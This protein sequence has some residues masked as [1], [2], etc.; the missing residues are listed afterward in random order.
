MKCRNKHIIDQ[1]FQSDEKII[2][3]SNHI[4]LLDPFILSAVTNGKI[5]YVF[6]KRLVE[7]IPGF[8]Y[9]MEH[10]VKSLVKQPKDTT[11]QIKS[12]VFSR[13]K[14][15]PILCLFADAMNQVPIDKNIAP[16]KTG[17]FV[18]KIPI[19]PII[20]KYKNYKIDPTYRWY[21]NE[22]FLWGFSKVLFDNNIDIVVDIGEPITPKDNWSIEDFR[23]NVYEMMNRKYELI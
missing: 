9:I 1:S 14:N 15:E 17:A 2:I 3:V 18:H 20:I 4:S 6:E 22:H 13:Q 23:D 8:K 10:Y 21:N 5:S 19:L 7:K 16:F 11:K 12:H